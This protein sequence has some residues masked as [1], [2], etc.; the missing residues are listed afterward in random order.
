MTDVNGEVMNYTTT[1]CNNIF[2]TSQ[3]P[4]NFANLTTSQTWDCN[5][6]VVT[7]S[8]DANGQTTHEDF[9]SGTS[10]D[11]FYRP[12]DSKDELNNVAT[13]AYTPNS[14]ESVFLFNGGASVIDTLSTTDS[15]GRSV[16]SQ[17][18]Q[19]PAPNANWDTKSRTFDSD[20]RAKQTSLTCVEPAGTACPASTESQTYDALNRPLIH[21]GTGGDIV[22]KTYPAND[23]LT[24]LTPAPNNENSK[25]TQKEYDGLGRLKSVCVISSA[26]GSGPCGQVNSKTG[27]LTTYT[28][29]AA[30]RLLKTVENAQVSSPQQPRTYTYDFLGRVLSESNPESGTTSYTHDT[31]SGTNCTSTSQGDLVQELDANGNTICNHYDKLHRKT[32]ITYAGPNSNNVS[33][34]FV[35]DAATVNSIAM[36]HA[37]GRMAEAYTCAGSG[38]PPCTPKITDEGF[39]YDQRG[40]MSAYYQ[41]S[42]NSNG[43]YTL[44][45]TYWEDHALKTVSGVGLPTLTYGSLDGEGRVQTVGASSGTNPVSA[46]AYNNGPGSDDSI[47]ALLTTTLGTGDTQNFTYYPT[48]GR[49]K[50]YSASVGATP[51]VI[52]GTLT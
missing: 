31:V 2:V 17:L 6:G 52:S 33:K 39:S 36:T 23:V 47:G 25:A 7:S 32:Y 45:A 19:G 16:T 3:Y 14:T 48:T 46:V 15:I 5:G 34:Y 13:F 9:Y 21:T 18:R 26:A 4:T 44:S 20:G 41:M 24:T 42:P 27:F 10:T 49:M 38:A 43:Y 22:T 1:S 28:Y 12:V 35:Y 11:P 51:V 50:T 29:D 37:E 8:T 30:G 40:Q